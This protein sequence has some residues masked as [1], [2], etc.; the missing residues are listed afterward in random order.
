MS[1]AA[2]Q[3]TDAFL[4]LQIVFNARMSGNI[5]CICKFIFIF[6]FILYNTRPYLTTPHYAIP[7]HLSRRLVLGLLPLLHLRM[8]LPC[9]FQETEHDTFPCKAFREHS[10]TLA[11]HALPPV[12][13]AERECEPI[14]VAAP[15]ALLHLTMRL[16]RV[17]ALVAAFG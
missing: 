11:H 12:T 8:C 1:L 2:D 15:A 10:W 4:S 6:I 7:L 5:I 16:F 14:V 17:P 3:W 9:W 13:L